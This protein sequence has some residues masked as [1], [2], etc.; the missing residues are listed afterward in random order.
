MAF[1]RPITRRRSSGVIKATVFQLHGPRQQVNPRGMLRQ[2]SLQQAEVQAGDVL[3]HVDQ[4][5]VGNGVEEDVGVAQAE[6]EVD[7][8]D[9]VLRVLGQ[10]AGQVHG[11]A[12]IAHAAQRTGHGHDLAAAGPALA[13][14]VAAFADAPQG[15]QQVVDPQRLGEEF[16]GPRPHRPQDQVA[17]VRR[18]G[19]QHG[20]LGRGLAEPRR[21]VPRPGRDRLSRATRPMSGLVWATTSAKNS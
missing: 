5:V 2:R 18:A 21:P 3:G 8:G 17:V 1:S 12:G 14:A 20:A 16:L 4:R 15:G 7:Q 6:V 13:G 11:Q 10:H 9:G 19:H